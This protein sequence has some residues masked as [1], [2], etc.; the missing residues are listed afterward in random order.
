MAK[1]IVANKQSVKEQLK[2]AEAL[3]ESLHGANNKLHGWLEDK[4][5]EVSALTQKTDELTLELAEL[6][7]LNK[8]QCELVNDACVEATKWRA[9][10]DTYLN[11]LVIAGR[12]AQAM[13][14]R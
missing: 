1:R 2:T 8:R 5:I 3:V 11:A 13:T 14:G 12:Q 7:R 9:R 4:R 6:K 10:A